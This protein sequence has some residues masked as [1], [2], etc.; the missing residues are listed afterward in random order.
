[1]AATI[2]AQTVP[3]AFTAPHIG[4]VRLHPE[5]APLG[6]PFL[7]LGGDA[8]L[9]LRYDDLSGDWPDHEWTLV[10]CTADWSDFTDLGD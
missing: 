5:G 10:H 8:R 3:V 9:V 2:R 1:M 6:G 7:E 4:A